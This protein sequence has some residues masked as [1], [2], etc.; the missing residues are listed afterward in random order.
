MVPF[1]LPQS[2]RLWYL[3]FLKKWATSSR[4]QAGKKREITGTVCREGR[5]SGGKALGIVGFL[6]FSKRGTSNS[7]RS[8]AASCQLFFSY[9]QKYLIKILHLQIFV[10]NNRIASCLAINLILLLGPSV[11][12]NFNLSIWDVIYAT[13]DFHYM[14]INWI[15]FCCSTITRVQNVGTHHPWI[16]C[17]EVRTNI[18]LSSWKVSTCLICWHTWCAKEGHKYVC[19]GKQLGC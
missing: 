18:I 8:K 19:D 9:L 11:P 17:K 14:K 4:K 12:L 3:H 7:L 1:L 2:S 6:S 16:L 5:G 13:H 10:N 15:A